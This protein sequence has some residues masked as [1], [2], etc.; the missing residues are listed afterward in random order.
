VTTIRAGAGLTTVF[1]CGRGA[2]WDEQSA[3][4]DQKS[5]SSAHTAKLPASN[6]AT[7]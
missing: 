1:R 3:N 2:Q 5:Q 4:P 6:T 7:R